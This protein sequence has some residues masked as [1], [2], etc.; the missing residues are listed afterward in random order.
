[1]RGRRREVPASPRGHITA[2]PG[3]VVPRQGQHRGQLRALVRPDDD[4]LLPRDA[5]VLLDRAAS[6]AVLRARRADPA[7]AV[8]APR[9]RDRHRLDGRLLPL[10]L[11]HGYVGQLRPLAP[12]ALAAARLA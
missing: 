2:L 11:H 12:R 7:V 1:A 3:A 8:P 6:P 5:A 4:A 9:D 10:A